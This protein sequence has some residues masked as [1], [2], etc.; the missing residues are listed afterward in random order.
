[1]ADPGSSWRRGGLSGVS[2]ASLEG[3]RSRAVVHQH[4]SCS[5]VTVTMEEPSRSCHGEGHVLRALFRG[6]F[7]GSSRG[8]GSGR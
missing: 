2:R 1:M 8:M 3:A 7:V 4:E 5:L 6:Q